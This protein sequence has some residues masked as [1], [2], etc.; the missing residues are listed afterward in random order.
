MSLFLKPI[1][2][3]YSCKQSESFLQEKPSQKMKHVSIPDTG[4]EEHH[5][6]QL[7]K[8]STDKRSL[9][10][11]KSVSKVFQCFVFQLFITLQ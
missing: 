4:Y 8:K 3:E 5:K 2:F 6:Y 7:L 9:T 11:F 1:I 10:C